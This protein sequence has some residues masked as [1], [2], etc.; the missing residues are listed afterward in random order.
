MWRDLPPDLTNLVFEELDAPEDR[1]AF[2]M[3]CRYFFAG[4]GRG[5]GWKRG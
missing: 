4:E 1:A 5:R 3:A 2:R